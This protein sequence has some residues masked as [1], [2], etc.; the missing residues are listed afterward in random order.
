MGVLWVEGREWYVRLME[1]RP[2]PA[3]ARAWATLSVCWDAAAIMVVSTDDAGG[4]QGGGILFFMRGNAQWSTRR[5][6]VQYV[7][8]LGICK[9]GTKF[10]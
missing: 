1:R 2:P 8:T 4:I 9:R 10:V 3:P 5:T 7:R 6:S